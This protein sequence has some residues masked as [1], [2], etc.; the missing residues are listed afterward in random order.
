[1]K[2]CKFLI[3]NTSSGIIEAASFD[4]HVLNLG[5]RQ[6]GRLAGDN[7]IH[8]PIKVAAMQAA[9]DKAMDS[10]SFGAHN[11]Y[12]NGGASSKIIK[13]LKSI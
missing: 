2:H 1:M 11:I 8:T 12:Y 10:P 6:E 13:A 9:I 4:K 5:D 3:G 7:V